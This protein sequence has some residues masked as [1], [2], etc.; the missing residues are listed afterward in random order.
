[1]QCPYPHFK[2]HFKRLS[3]PLNMMLPS[4]HGDYVSVPVWF[5]SLFCAKHNQLMCMP[6]CLMH[7]TAFPSKQI[8]YRKTIL[9]L[10]STSGTGALL[11]LQKE[12]KEKKP[13]WR[14]QLEDR[15]LEGVSKFHTPSM[16]RIATTE[17]TFRSVFGR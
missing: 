3:P 11:C 15:I 17:H 12:N 4:M 1:V 7:M 5:K 13:A 10:F 14:S 2:T 8:P 9:A 16:Q 6:C